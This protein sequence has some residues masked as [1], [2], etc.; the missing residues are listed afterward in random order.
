[1][2]RSDQ[3]HIFISMHDVHISRLLPH[4]GLV[5]DDLA[6][7]WRSPTPQMP[8][9]ECHIWRPELPLSTDLLMRM[10]HNIYMQSDISLCLQTATLGD[11]PCMTIFPHL[12]TN[13][14]QHCCFYFKLLASCVRCR[15][16]SMARML[17]CQRWLSLESQRSVKAAAI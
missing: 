8:Y 3:D 17:G 16:W 13:L 9:W 14:R 1:M 10:I 5:L 4:V 6:A 11:G 12:L 2:D 15:G 7:V